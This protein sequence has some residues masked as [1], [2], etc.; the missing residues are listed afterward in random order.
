MLFS[1]R[2]T[3]KNRFMLV[4]VAVA[5]AVF[6]YCSKL[7]LILSEDV[8]SLGILGAVLA[9][10][11]Y[12]FGM[13]TPTAFLV[14]LEA[15]ALNNY[16]VIAISAALTAALVDTV[17]FM[18]FKQ[19]LEKNASRLIKNIRKKA[20]RHNGIFSI[21]GFFLFGSPLPDELGLAFMEISEIKPVRIFV[22]VF[23]AKV[24][25]LL[26]TYAALHNI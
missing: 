12:T 21:I 19:Q 24:L 15:M 14:L 13:T 6:V 25:T 8:H 7:D 1:G 23:L 9:G 3:I 10:A 2:L 22:I 26:L 16:V 11:F 4:I 17:L 5:I 18:L 20:G